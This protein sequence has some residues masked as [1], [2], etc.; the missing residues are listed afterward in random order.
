MVLTDIK[1]L[2]QHKDQV[3]EIIA[4]QHLMLF[5]HDFNT[6]PGL[7]TEQPM[8]DKTFLLVGDHAGFQAQPERKARQYFQEDAA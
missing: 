8:S 4:L 7:D 5:L 2:L 6:I 3:V 1:S